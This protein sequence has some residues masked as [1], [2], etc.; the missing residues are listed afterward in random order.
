[1]T[2]ICLLLSSGRDVKA[3]FVSDEFPCKMLLRNISYTS[4]DTDLYL[5]R[6]LNMLWSITLV[7]EIGELISLVDLEFW[8][9]HCVLI[10]WG[11]FEVNS[12]MHFNQLIEPSEF[13]NTMIITLWVKFDWKPFS[14]FSV[15]FLFSS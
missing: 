15:L 11:I 9:L 10:H 7:S 1:M 12:F 5:W 4:V 13:S 2:W 8:E 6:D 14:L 3:L